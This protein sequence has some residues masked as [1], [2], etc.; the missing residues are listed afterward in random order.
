LRLWHRSAITCE[1]PLTMTPHAFHLL[2]LSQ[3]QAK[4]V[5]R[6]GVVEFLVGDKVFAALGVDAGLATVRLSPAD[7]AAAIAAAPTVFSRQAGGAGL[8]GVTC[9][10]LSQAEERH[11]APVLTLAANKARNAR[12]AVNLLS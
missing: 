3:F 9:V 10:R 2:A 8:R 4:V 11:L 1:P 12:S 5:T 6:L 7:Q